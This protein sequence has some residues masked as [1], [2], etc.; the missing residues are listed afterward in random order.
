[1]TLKITQVSVN[2]GFK[3][4]SPNECK[5]GST[6]LTVNREIVFVG[7]GGDSDT[8]RFIML[9]EKNIRILYAHDSDGDGKLDLK[10][11]NFE[12]NILPEQVN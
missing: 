1:M 3:K 4:L 6:Y 9:G 7:Q 8:N 11:A 5:R 10:P 12:I 2:Y